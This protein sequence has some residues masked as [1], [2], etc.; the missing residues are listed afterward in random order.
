MK[1]KMKNI[2]HDVSR[3]CLKFPISEGIKKPGIFLQSKNIG[4]SGIRQNMDLVA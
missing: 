3:R 1:G 2:W 4:D